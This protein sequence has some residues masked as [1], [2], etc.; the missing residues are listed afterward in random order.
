MKESVSRKRKP[1][2]RESAYAKRAR[3]TRI[4]SIFKKAYPDAWCSLSFHTSFQLLISTILSA[5]CTDARV[6]MVSPALFEKYPDAVSMAKAPIP[7]LESLIRST[8]FYH[9]K[10][11]ALHETSAKLV[12]DFSGQV[13]PEMSSLLTLRGV[14][15][16]TANIVLFH[17][18][19]QNVGIAVDTHCMR[20]SYRLGFTSSREQQNKIEKELMALIPRED[21][22][23]YT[24]WMVSHGRKYCMARKPDCAGCPLN[25][26]CPSAFKA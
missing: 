12:H 5:Q 6:N 14:A 24:N 10:A 1:V 11:K 18:F 9:S 4:L 20:V 2:R 23:M 7:A 17:S 22:G 19:G 15:R 25:K 3:A 13:P 26:L 21:W 16:K 8:G